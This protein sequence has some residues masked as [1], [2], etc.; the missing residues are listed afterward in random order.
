M[1]GTLVIALP[2]L[3]G[4]PVL[5][6]LFADGLT[7]SGRALAD[8]PAERAD[9]VWA[10]VPGCD[11]LMRRV[12]I[13]ARSDAQARAALPYLLEDDV[14]V[15]LDGLHF[16]MGPA[17]G[18]G[19]RAVAVVSKAK[20]D[21]WAGLLAEAG[22]KA[23]RLVA[24]F[25]AVAGP[26]EKPVLVDLGARVIAGG[27]F[28]VE[29]D[30]AAR[31]LGGRDEIEADA[32]RVT[33]RELLG[34]YYGGLAA[35]APVNLLQGAYTPRPPLKETLS[36]WRIAA[37]LAL[38]V[39]VGA[40]AQSVLQTWRYQ[41]SAEA[42]RVQAEQAFREAFPEV[43]RVVNPRT[44]LRSE[45][46]ALRATRADGFFRLS[47]TLFDGIETMEGVRIEALRFDAE[48]GE[49]VADL[50]YGSFDD[51]ERLRLAVAEH[52]ARLEEGG[53]RQQGGRIVGDVTVS[54][55]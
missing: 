16:A 14:A 15:E 13:P 2:A 39:L 26:D 33:D 53:S 12:E 55:P 44:Q 50:S 6:G 31:I 43:G 25:E 46:A 40:V 20:M 48:R 45:L 41:E 21:A 34:L 8:V 38:L 3:P 22:I 49:I 1:S 52:G 19:R 23:D 35:R 17:G 18:D 5:W 4:D 11:V 51:V 54:L 42:Y 24:D 27:G 47:Q 29:T 9:Q 30:L 10:V 32:L 7:A 28:S 36:A 37:V